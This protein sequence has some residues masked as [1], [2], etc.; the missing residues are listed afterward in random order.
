MMI[1]SDNFSLI[2]GG[3]ETGLKL[4]FVIFDNLK[5]CLMLRISLLEC[6]L[7]DQFALVKMKCVSHL[8]ERGPVLHHL[9]QL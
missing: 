2:F 1:I 6:Y 3:L 9:H 4:V 7:S 8:I 5:P